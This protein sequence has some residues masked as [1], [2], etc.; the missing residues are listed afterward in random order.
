M[1]PSRKP[2]SLSL[3]P[4]YNG[5]EVGPRST[6]PSHMPESG[7]CARIASALAGNSCSHMTFLQSRRGDN[8][9]RVS[10]AAPGY[11]SIRIVVTWVCTGSARIAI[12]PKAAPETQKSIADWLPS[13]PHRPLPL[14]KSWSRS[15]QC[16]SPVLWFH[17]LSLRHNAVHWQER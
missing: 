2:T 1:A 13:S 15:A 6:V 17:R 11:A 9:R 16:R 8:V 12:M 10:L 4:A 14:A 7:N 3:L 5:Y